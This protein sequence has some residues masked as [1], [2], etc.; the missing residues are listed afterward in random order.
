MIFRKLKQFSFLLICCAILFY[1]EPSAARQTIVKGSIGT[2]Y[3][4]QERDY[5]EEPEGSIEGDRREFSFIPEVEVRSLD[6]HNVVTLRYSP[7]LVYDDLASE[8]DVDHYLD[9]TGEQ[10]I[11]KNWLIEVADNFVYTTD[12]GR[13]GTTFETDSAFLEGEEI[14]TT[15]VD[16]LSGDLGRA[17]FWTNDVSLRTTYTYY[18]DSDVELGYAFRVLRNDSDSGDGGEAYDEFDK[19]E[20]SALWLHRINQFYKS[21]AGLI[22][23]RG[24]FD[25]DET[26]GLSQDLDEY[27][28]NLGLTYERDASN[29]FPLTYRLA[30]S[31]YEDTREDTLVH[32][33]TASWEHIFSPRTRMEIGAGPSYVTAEDSDSEWDFNALFSLERDYQHGNISLRAGKNQLP[34]NFTGSEDGGLTDTTYVE[35]EANYQY[36]KD[37]SSSLFAGYIYEDILDPQGRFLVSATGGTLPTTSGSIGDDSYTREEISIGA[38]VEYR[39]MRWFVASLRYAFLQQ[40]GDLDTDSYDDH[41]I[42]FFISGSKDLFQW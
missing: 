27:R 10:Y 15:D 9:L 17:R 30:A 39:F 11:S 37:I 34:R 14:E 1:V 25:D 19:H 32:E 35:I 31:E 4:Y 42:T 24:L 2:G 13:F 6:V 3:D 29:T 36:T 26:T 20:L 28:A 33:L 16:E 38:Q 18:E 23:V 7:V 40:D 5:D 21:E 8:T 12:P 22:Y 41:R